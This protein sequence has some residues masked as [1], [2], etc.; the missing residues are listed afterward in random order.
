LV[1]V[2]GGHEWK[3]LRKKAPTEIL[4]PGFVNRPQ[5]WFSAFD[6]YVS[7]ASY[8]PFGLVFLEAFAAGLP[9]LSTAT[10]GAQLFQ[11]LIGRPLLKCGDVQ[12]MAEG[13]QQFLRERPAKRSYDLS[14]FNYENQVNRIEA[15]YKKQ[16]AR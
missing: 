5:D 6:G 9:V 13:L 7:A 12:S 8:E 1:I 3:A 4:M 16:S 15:F 11:A 2:G 14:D 10:E